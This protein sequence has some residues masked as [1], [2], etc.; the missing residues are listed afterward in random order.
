MAVYLGIDLGTTGLKSLLVR[1]DGSICGSG[2]RE[3]PLSVPAPGY[4]EQDP[5]DWWR[6]LRETVAEALSKAGVR[7]EE[8]AAIGLS[9]QMHGT[10]LLGG[11]GRPLAPFLHMQL[12]LFQVVLR[13]FSRLI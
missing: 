5:K 4:A 11:D 10:V 2:Y 8:V 9:G 6:A 12:L 3:Y 1:P 13:L 7:G